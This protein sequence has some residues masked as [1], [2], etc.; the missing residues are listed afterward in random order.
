VRARFALG[1]KHKVTA[2]IVFVLL[3]VAAVLWGSRCQGCGEFFS[4]G[5]E[6]RTDMGGGYTQEY[7]SES[8]SDRPK[9]KRVYRYRYKEI[10]VCRAC[11]HTNT[12]TKSYAKP[13]PT[14]RFPSDDEA[15]SSPEAAPEGPWDTLATGPW[16]TKVGVALAVAVVLFV[17]GL[18]IHD[19]NV[20]RY[21]RRFLAYF[22]GYCGFLMSPSR[23]D[24][25]RKTRL[26][27]A[28]AHWEKSFPLQEYDGT[29]W[30]VVR[31][32][33]WGGADGVVQPPPSGWDRGFEIGGAEGEAGQRRAGPTSEKYWLRFRVPGTETSYAAYTLTLLRRSDCADQ[34]VEISKA[35]FDYFATV[36][37]GS[38]WKGYLLV[39]RKLGGGESE[40][41]LIKVFLPDEDWTTLVESSS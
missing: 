4:M 17:V 37:A 25:Y 7:V 35:H 18:P 33:K 32:V 40:D 9:V 22:E 24:R 30:Q 26:E 15:G 2:V 31:V 39:W 11:G 10:D 6:S 19:M 41:A 23:Y 8:G 21:P 12:S 36:E 38:T 1:T 13:Q 27:L 34:L 29:E 28:G 3:A 20:F 16:Y 14:G 5:F